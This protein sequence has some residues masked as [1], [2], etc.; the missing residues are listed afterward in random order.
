MKITRRQ[1]RRIV[2]EAIETTRPPRIFVLVGP[3]SVGKSTWIKNTFRD[4]IPYVINRDDIVEQ[5]ASTYGWTYD[6][7]FV[8][9][10]EDATIGESDE[11]Y[12]EVQVSPS[13]MTW[14]Q[15][16]F[17]LVMEAN[18]AVQAAFNQRVSGAVPSGLDVIVDMTNMNAAARARALNAIE[19]RQDDYEKIAVDFKFEG[20]EDVI[21]RVAQKRAEAAARM[22]KS[23]TIPPAA[24]QRMMGAYEA[25][26]LDEGFDSIVEMDNREILRDLADQD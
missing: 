26:S 17:S 3:P 14:A 6:D 10:P 21:M 4:T 19:G 18:G 13:W 9:P 1:L 8:T 2:K 25:P 22:G 11:K 12:G 7:M 5:V 24:M 16:V 20:A 15:S 23:K